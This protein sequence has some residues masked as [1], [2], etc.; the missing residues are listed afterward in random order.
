MKHALRIS[1]QICILL[2]LGIIVGCSEDNAPVSPPPPPPPAPNP[3]GSFGVYMDAD[4]TNR[5]ITDT[6]GLVTLYICQTVKDGS[7]GSAFSVDVPGSWTHVGTNVPFPVHVGDDP[8]TGLAIGYGTCQTGTFVIA[9][10]TYLTTGSAIGSMI[11]VLAHPG[12]PTG[13]RSTDCTEPYP[14]QYFDGEGLESPIVAP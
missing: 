11:K 14:V 6:G 5:N 4:A 2:A 9:T 7:T 3:A 8:S 12:Y 1:L 13:I 10:S